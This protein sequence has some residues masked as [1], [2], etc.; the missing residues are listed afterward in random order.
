[1][2]KEY[3]Q[4]VFNQKVNV[5]MNEIDKLPQKDTNEHLGRPPSQD[6]V[7]TAIKRMSSEKA[8]GKSGVTT[9][10]LKN[11]PTEGFKLITNFIKSYWQ[12]NN[13]DFE[14]WYTNI[15]SLLYKSKD[16]SKDPKNWR[17]I[18]LKETTAK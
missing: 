18:C 10:M 17:P 2:I 11:L 5:E 15:L 14:S 6:E 8:P 3:Y 12:D 16:D 13:C 7:T 1:V 9:D 4:E